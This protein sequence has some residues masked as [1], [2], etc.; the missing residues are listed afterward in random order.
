MSSFPS[1]STLASDFFQIGLVRRIEN[2]L[3]TMPHPSVVVE[4]AEPYVAV[5]RWAG[6]SGQLEELAVEPLPAGAVMPSTLETNVA[7]PESVRTALRRL[8][9]RVSIAGVP[10]ALIVPDLVVRVL[11][12]PFDN[13][14]RRSR[15]AL[16]LLKWRLKKSVPFDVDETTISW[17]R[18]TG[19][20]GALEIVTAVSRQ[21]IVREYETLI[22]SLGGRVGVVLGSTLATLPLLKELGSTL[23]VRLC[24]RTLSTVVVSGESLCVYRSTEMRGDT[25]S[26]EPLGVLDE[27]FPAAA[28][29]QDSWGAS[30]DSVRLSGFGTRE[31]AFGQALAEELKIP[32]VSMNDLAT[33]QS[34]TGPARDLIPQGLD[35]LAG[36][37]M[38]ARV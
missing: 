19:R 15:E 38:N 18:Q 28:Y 23:L 36:W 11:I 13:L 6:K 4:I 22:E 12:L 29:Y 1:Q 34:L 9:S 37:M 24:G 33:A 30:I 25:G 3:Q 17:M 16:P 35:A 14:P 32:V 7:Q 27:V 8:F 26:I 10:V 21:P 20:E 2:W 31:A 5:A